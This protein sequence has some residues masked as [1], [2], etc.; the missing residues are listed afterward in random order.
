MLTFLF[1][2]FFFSSCPSQFQVDA[3]MLTQDLYNN[4][5]F[6]DAV[7][8]KSPPQT[9]FYLN[10]S[11]P[12]SPSQISTGRQGSWRLPPAVQHYEF[13]NPSSY[14]PVGGDAGTGDVGTVDPGSSPTQMA[15]AH[16]ATQWSS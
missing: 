9:S 7:F 13:L 2:F 1:F 14:V 4:P 12:R 3:P 15:T 16:N 11:L 6:R 5:Q 8:K 10:Y